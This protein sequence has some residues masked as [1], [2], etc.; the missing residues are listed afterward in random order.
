MPVQILAYTQQ[1]S[2]SSSL[3][4]SQHHFHEAPLLKDMFYA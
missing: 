1:I 4:K 2:Q 3:Q